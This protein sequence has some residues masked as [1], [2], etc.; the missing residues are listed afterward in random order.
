MNLPGLLYSSVVMHRRTR[1]HPYRFVYRVFS[2]LVDIDRLDDL[3]RLSPILSVN[4]FNVFS[5]HVADHLA[6][7]ADTPRAWVNRVLREYHVQPEGL[8]IKLLCFPR[9]LG[10][11]FNPLSVWFCEDEQGSPR[12][13]ICE[14]RNTFGERH[15]YL[16]SPGRKNAWPVMQHCK[17]NFHVSPF[18]PMETEY[19]FR[20]ERPGE[21]LSVIIEEYENNELL[22]VA[23][24]T[25]RAQPITTRSLLSQF[26]R[27]PFQTIKVLVG[28]HWHALKIWLNG[29]HFYSKP[30]PPI[31][32]IS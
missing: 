24:Q 17:K 13:I 6:N 25:G 2:L 19:R 12:A 21:Q 28:I 8:I 5:F 1:P 16:L 7:D 26:V 4:K 30:S 18:I 10:L 15:C 3:D 29:A 22:L 27:V 23:S 14:V 20:I 9:I 31:K 11:V 32:E